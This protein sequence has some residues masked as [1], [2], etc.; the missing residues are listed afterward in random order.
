MTHLYQI[1]GQFIGLK[2]L[3][4][5]GEMDAQA[6]EDTLEALEGDL[7]VK[8]E[9]LLS[10]VANIGSDVAAIDTE[11]K[12]LQKRKTTMTNRQESLRD[13]LKLNMIAGEIQKIACP[14]FSITLTKQRDV[15]VIDYPNNIPDEYLKVVTTSRPVKADILKALK[16]G[17]DVPG[18]S[19][20]KSQ[21]GLLIK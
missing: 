12:R 13:Y 18:A 15:C 19:L 14:L 17:K 2:N 4:E 20:G 6:L 16:A 3:I 8:A 11:I 9:G 10:Y 5:D 7:Q 1:T 21:H